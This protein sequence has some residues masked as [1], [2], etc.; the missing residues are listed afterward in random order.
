MPVNPKL[1]SLQ[2]SQIIEAIYRKGYVE[3]EQINGSVVRKPVLQIYTLSSRKVRGKTSRKVLT[4]GFNSE[5]QRNFYSILLQICTV[6]VFQNPALLLEA[7]ELGSGYDRDAV[8][9]MFERVKKEA[10]YEAAGEYL[11]SIQVNDSK[12]P[13]NINNAPEYG[14]NI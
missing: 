11:L 14:G 4:Q 10:P 7:K 12:A 3:E 8:V 6:D 9:E 2:K 5:H 1:I 13:G